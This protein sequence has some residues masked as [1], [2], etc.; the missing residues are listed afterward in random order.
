MKILEV[1]RNCGTSFLT[2]KKLIFVGYAVAE[3]DFFL[4]N[5][6]R[7]GSIH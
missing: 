6:T 7:N 2:E 3:K 1:D 4:N 5:R